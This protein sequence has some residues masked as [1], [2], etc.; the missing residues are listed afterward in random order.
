MRRQN[1]TVFVLLEIRAATKRL[2]ST[3][4]ADNGQRISVDTEKTDRNKINPRA[5]L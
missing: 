3:K 5:L 1:V 4:T 2:A